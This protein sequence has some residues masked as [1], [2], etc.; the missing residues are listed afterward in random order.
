[1][2]GIFQSAEC[3]IVKSQ[4]VTWSFELASDFGDSDGKRVSGVSTTLNPKNKNPDKAGSESSDDL[5]TR[6]FKEIVNSFILV[7][8]FLLLGIW[9]GSLISDKIHNR[10]MRALMKP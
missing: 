7:P 1:M 2:N 6:L 5:P 8:I 9:V 10:R 3:G 4:R